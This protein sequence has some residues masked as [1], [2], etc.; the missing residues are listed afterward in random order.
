MLGRHAHTCDI[1]VN[2]SLFLG[3][4]FWGGG[5]VGDIGLTID[6]TISTEPQMR[7]GWLCQVMS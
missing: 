4:G 2:M 5:G 1:I 6:R 3:K 7:R